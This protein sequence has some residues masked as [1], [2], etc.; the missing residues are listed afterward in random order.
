MC[1]IAVFEGSVGNTAE[2]NHSG[3][4]LFQKK[5]SKNPGE[6]RKGM[7]ADLGKPCAGGRRQ[8]TRMCFICDK[9][10]ILGS[11]TGHPASVLLPLF[12]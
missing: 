1:L 2:R 5:R 3:E 9:L 12:N 10:S 8:S 6:I 11:Q 7:F 4:E